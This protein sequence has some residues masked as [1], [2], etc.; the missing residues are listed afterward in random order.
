MAQITPNMALVVWNNLSDPYNS[1]QLV[2][3][4]VKIDAHD[5]TGGTKGIR[6]D[7]ALAIQANTITSAQLGTN[8]VNYDGLSKSTTDDSNRAV[9]T[10]TIKTGAVTTD[11]IAD[12]S[13]TMSKLNGIITPIVYHRNTN[14]SLPSTTVNGSSLY[15]GYTIDYAFDV[16]HTSDAW[17]AKTD[18]NYRSFIWRLRY[19]S[20]GSSWD[21][22]GGRSVSPARTANVT[23]D[24]ALVEGSFYGG[25]DSTP[26]LSFALPL[27]GSYQ[28]SSYA[29]VQSS[30][31]TSA[32][33]KSALFLGVI[34]SATTVTP[35][36]NSGAYTSVN[37]NEFS[38]LNI[39]PFNVAT[40]SNASSANVVSNVFG[41]DNKPTG[42]PTLKIV[43]Q[44]LIITPTSLTN[45]S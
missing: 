24:G 35:L 34:A 2:D 12:G 4:F 9:G 29:V 41:W 39:L 38:T 8:S 13:I 27:K 15:D 28:V 36:S 21:F 1:A 17:S 33:M 20:S 18:A 5:H 43:N 3:N 25:W 14:G 30:G 10:N 19:N 26:F 7:G 31:S 6:L 42:T 32:T 44:Q 22:I 23:S 37:G 40:S 11:K 45:Y 16:T